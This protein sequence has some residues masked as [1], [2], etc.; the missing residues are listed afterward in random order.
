MGTSDLYSKLLDLFK[1]KGIPRGVVAKVYVVLRLDSNGR[2][3]RQRLH[4]ARLLASLIICC[5]PTHRHRAALARHSRE[6][7][8]L[9]Q[10]GLGSFCLRL[11]HV[12]DDISML[13]LL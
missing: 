7:G 6:Y 3:P 12:S 2:Q 8:N 10:L 9:W 1:E 11:C 5:A 13:C 4:G